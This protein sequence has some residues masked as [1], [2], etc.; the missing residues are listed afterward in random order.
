MLLRGACAFLNFDKNECL[1]TRIE[2]YAYAKT[3]YAMFHSH[4]HVTA[5][6]Q[7]NYFR[8]ILKFETL[9]VLTSDGMADAGRYFG[10]NKIN[11]L[12]PDRLSI[13]LFPP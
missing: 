10:L 1:S 3:A 11:F 2:K 7:F 6:L 4:C 8:L 9:H 13:V 5:L 12:S